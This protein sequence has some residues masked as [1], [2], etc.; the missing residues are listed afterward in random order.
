M[1]N[2]NLRKYLVENK[3]TTNS[4]MMNEAESNFFGD[5]AEAFTTFL[6]QKV[7]PESMDEFEFYDNSRNIEDFMEYAPTSTVVKLTVDAL[8]A[9]GVDSVEKLYTINTGNY[10]GE[11]VVDF[12]NTLEIEETYRGGIITV[13]PGVTLHFSEEV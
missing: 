13:I 11:S 12:F 6:E 9:A 10:N 7:G 4:K 8:K 5:F 1:D 3:V 2:F